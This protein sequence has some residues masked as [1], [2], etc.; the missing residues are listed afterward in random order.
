MVITFMM[1]YV[2]SFGS[3]ASLDTA[4]FRNASLQTDDEDMYFGE[5]DRDETGFID[6][7]I[8]SGRM[9]YEEEQEQLRRISRGS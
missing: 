9:E 5:R 4:S 7:L 1:S 3:T 2:A 6:D 8:D